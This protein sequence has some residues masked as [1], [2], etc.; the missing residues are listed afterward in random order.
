MVFL[1][2]NIALMSLA[3]VIHSIEC[4]PNIWNVTYITCHNLYHICGFTVKV[5]SMRVGVVGLIRNKLGSVH[6]EAGQ[7][8]WLPAR[9]RKCRGN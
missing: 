6:M 9:L 7:A 1:C 5:S 8:S 4:F 3:S 2:S